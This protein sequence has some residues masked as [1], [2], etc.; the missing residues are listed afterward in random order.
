MGLAGLAAC[1]ANLPPAILAMPSYNKGTGE[2]RMDVRKVR[3]GVR[4]CIRIP[5]GKQDLL[6]ILVGD[7]IIQR[8]G[9][10]SCGC[11]GNN[12]FYRMV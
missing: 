6:D 12:V 1:A 4:G 7:R 5:P 9:D 10:S 2:F 11:S 8:P 3:Y